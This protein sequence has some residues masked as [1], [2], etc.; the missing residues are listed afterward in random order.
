MYLQSEA[1]QKYWFVHSLAVFHKLTIYFRNGGILS[2]AL[3]KGGQKG[4]FHFLKNF[5]M[6]ITFIIQFSVSSLREYHHHVSHHHHDFT[7]S[8]VSIRSLGFQ[9]HQHVHFMHKIWHRM[10]CDKQVFSINSN[11]RGNFMFLYVISTS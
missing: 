9:S 11:F 8:S 3:F 7:Q 4:Y 5:Y 2:Y 1:I 10:S 6:P